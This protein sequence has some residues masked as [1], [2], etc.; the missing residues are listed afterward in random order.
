LSDKLY[1][2]PGARRD[3]IREGKAAFFLMMPREKGCE[4]FADQRFVLRIAREVC[5]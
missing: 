4:S 1:R 3:S 2:I 5:S